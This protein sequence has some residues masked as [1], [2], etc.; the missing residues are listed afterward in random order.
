MPSHHTIDIVEV[1]IPIP[2][3]A[4][5]S[6]FIPV[7]LE[8]LIQPGVQVLVPFGERYVSGIVVAQK[9]IKPETN[10]ELKPL[11]DVISPEPFI[12]G[13]LLKLLEWIS[14][15]Y[16]C[17]LGEAYRL[18]N[19]SLNLHK[20][21]FEVKRNN[22]NL[23][24]NLSPGL[25]E[26]IELL[27]LE[28]WISLDKLEATLAQK[29]LLYRV[30]KL[31]KLGVVETRYL[32]PKVRKIYKTIDLFELLPH[33]KWRPDALEKYL[34]SHQKKYERARE[35]IAFMTA[36]E[37]KPVTR[38]E[39]KEGRFTSKLINRLE[40]EGVLL[41]QE[42]ENY[43]EQEIHFR[44]E[45][46]NIEPSEEQ[47]EF[48]AKVL[49]CL[50]E[51]PQHRTFL[52]H[53]I[54]GSGKT[55]IYIELIKK[56]LEQQ[57]QAVVL[58]PEIVLTPQTLARFYN[59]FKDRVA[60]IHSRLSAGEKLEVLQ[61]IRENKFD[62]VIGP[63]SAVF[64]PFVNLGIIIVDEEHEGSYKQSDGVPRYN[65]RDVAL[66]RAYLN[67]IPVILGSATPSLE[68]LHNALTGKHEYSYL[69]KRISSRNLPRTQLVDFKEEWRRSGDFQILSE[70]LLLKM[71][72]RLVSREQGMLLQN[73]RG[74]S[75]YILCHECGY[76]ERCPNCDITLTYHFT[77]KN[78]RCHYCGFKEPAP[79][80]CP[81]CRGFDILYKGIGTQKIE[82]EAK[83][84]FPYARMLRMD[85]DTTRRRHDHAIILEKFRHYEADFL[86]GTKMIAKGLDFGRVTLVGI[87]NADQ[88]LHFPDF[89]ASEKA[90]QL[91]VQAAGRAG[92]GA[93]SG[94]VVIQTFD[95]N[96]Y[97]F[98]FL[99]TH[100]Y[101][102]FYE[103]EIET[104]KN[105]NYPPYSRLCLIRFIGETED[106]VF[107]CG[108]EIAKYLRQAA[109]EKKFTVLGPA[110]SPLARINNR[111]RYQILVKQSREVDPAMSYVRRLIKEGIYKNPEI[112][113]W[114]VEIQID[115]DP[116]EIL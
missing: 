93:H 58:I 38:Q 45:K 59:H 105:L 72:A 96:H 21:K 43:R 54:T 6:Y 27:P 83:E 107:S 30:H 14:N 109:R 74:F 34:N 48:I 69:S 111:Y 32:P 108:Q 47:E 87:V 10:F 11:Y 7:E 57:R 22:R 75:P 99:L 18:V 70:S 85:Q 81:Q 15:Y 91:M 94:E 73:R 112:K 63:R 78:L 104:R 13:D 92:R 79:D 26:L 52:L 4:P 53:G 115:M 100:D 90:F 66:Y 24:E 25:R 80:V 44:E 37:N 116:L 61:K 49:P 46:E 20:S 77:D 51:K 110:P 82:E 97:I 86:I 55:Q 114:P 84:R 3:D 40:A 1:V 19:P 28:D 88:G 5:F 113:K 12:C 106:R 31:R 68:S 71:E 33:E 36:R 35:L 56:V 62:I 98:K 39:L 101:I 16:I 23:P 8:E 29:N 102:K 60:V 76:V 65:A 64:A 50:G 2:V 41:R 9:K 103:R 42:K 17:H 95:T 89:R 67:N